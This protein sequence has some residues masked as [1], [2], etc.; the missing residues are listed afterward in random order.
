M[1]TTIVTA[2]LTAILMIPYQVSANP[3]EVTMVPNS[4]STTIPASAGDIH[5]LLIGAS[6]PKLVLQTPDGKAFDLN[7]TVKERPTVLIF[8]RGGWCPY[9]N[10]Q[11]GQLQTIE[12]ELLKL[13]YQILAISPDRPSKLGESVEKHKLTYTLL[14]DHAMQAAQVFGIAFRVDD[15]TLKKYKGY[16]I[17]LEASSG[18]KHRLLP[19][20]SVFIAGKDG[21]IKFAYVN[22]DYKVRLAPDELLSAART[23]AT[24]VT[25]QVEQILARVRDHAF[26]PVRDG[27]TFDRRLNKHG[28]ADLQD[29]DW[30]VRTLAVRD[31]VRLG[32]EATPGLTDALQD[33][34]ANVRHMAAMTLGIIRATTAVPALVNALL[35]DKDVVVRS[36]SAIALGLIGQTNALP[37]LRQA[38]TEDKSRD[39]RHQAELAA[40]AVEHGFGATPGLAA[41]YRELDESH[42]GQIRIGGPAVD[43]ELSDT[44]GRPWRLSAFR[45]KKAVALIWIFADWCPV[46]H[47]EF[48]E[49]IELR[50]EFEAAGVEVATLECHDVFAARVMVGKELEPQYWF[51][52]TPFK[53]SY[54]KNIWWPHLVDRAGAVGARYGA[55][56]M[57]FAVHSEYINRPSVV[58]VDKEGI[59]RFAYY[60]TF[61]GDRPSIRQALDMAQ[62]GRYEFE[63]DRRL[64]AETTVKEETRQ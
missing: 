62:S 3:N 40:Y 28:V 4:A 14:S 39:V 55:Q 53:E 47:G 27:F 9:C 48:R 43:F 63:S 54:T 34:G 42:F 32:G 30:R 38:Q 2:A 12:P 50:K 46:C 18:E 33:A 60:G 1:K 22:P 6:V 64:K 59:V 19:V 31:L 23:A 16:G 13:G 41:A 25:G 44:E 15:A 8:Y 58:I 52:K 37:S 17:D 49:L 5:P 45:G 24:A 57:T 10:T 61:W 21:L 29:D 26:H 36:Q 11:L 56:P 51:S 7:Q 35:G 20:P